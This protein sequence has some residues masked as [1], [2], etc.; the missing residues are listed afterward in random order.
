MSATPIFTLV[1][2]LPENNLT[3][4][5]LHALDFVAP[6]QW[7]N[8][9]GFENTIKVIT[10]ETDQALIQKIG[11]RAIQL[12]NDRSQGYQRALWLYHT[13]ESVSNTMGAA[14]LAN[15]VGEQFRIASLLQ[16]ITPKS[17]KAQAIDFSVKM[18]VELVTFCLR[19]GLPGDS[20]GDF[21]K[22]LTHYKDE[23]LIRMAALI[24][25]DGLLPLGPGYVQKLTS[26]I[27]GSGAS[28]LEHNDTF[29]RV[30]SLVP[31]GDVKGQLG[32]IQQGVSSVQNWM[33]NFTAQHA[34]T[35]DKVLGSFSSFLETTDNRLDYIAAFL[36]LTTNYFE[37]TGTQSVARSL[38]ERAVNEI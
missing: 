32:F 25:V 9:V 30:K 19:N 4:K 20:I 34:L 3:T 17:D 14:A 31:G 35:T 18:I 38:I 21:V 12:Y 11:E 15:K 16:K 27:H 24:C 37:H 26:I 13:A 29:Q 2:K 6:G 28:D 23:A 8:L 36:D 5:M 22:S 33:T 10:G 1:D 7:R